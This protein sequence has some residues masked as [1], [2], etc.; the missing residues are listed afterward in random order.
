MEKNKR[1][2]ILLLTQDMSSRG[3]ERQLLELIKYLKNTNNYDLRIVLSR[4]KIEYPFFFDLK[5]PFD[6]VERKLF[7]KDPRLFFLLYRICKAFR[8]DI[9]HVWSGMMAFYVI[10]ASAVLKIPVIN[11]QIQT[12]PITYRKFSFSGLVNSI[13]FMFAK[14]VIANSQAG[15]ESFSVNKKKSSVVYN[16]VDL[17][18][19]NN[20]PDPKAVKDKYNIGT[21][22]A[23]VMVA[24][25]SADKKYDLFLAA[26]ELLTEMREDVTFVGV[27]ETI[28]SAEEYIRIKK[29]AKANRRVILP[30]KIDDVE[31][32]INAC[33]IGVLLTY[34][35][36]ISN[37]LIEYMALCKP[38]IASEGG[39]TKE[40]IQHGVNGYLLY[41]DDPEK[42]AL[43]IND[44]LDDRQKR[45]SMGKKGRSLIEKSF[46]IEM[47]GKAMEKAYKSVLTTIKHDRNGS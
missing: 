13:N 29:K 28:S 6:I 5:I 42:I 33:D 30:G 27:G 37:A 25:F 32:L 10:P 40:I 34:S 31:A 1:T 47:M 22:Y 11:Y 16:G 14:L 38:V 44:L 4:D 2:K 7:R 9:I 3:L 12:A 8:P 41:E 20:L 35:E 21:I 19:F 24:A 26:A 39:G 23:I 36:G 18:R 17:S 46:S 43:M 45:I 15:L